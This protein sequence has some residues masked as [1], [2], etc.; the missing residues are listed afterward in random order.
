MEQLFR[1]RENGT[2][3]LT[4][5]R[6]G[7]TTFIA[8]AYIIFLNPVF[9][10]ATGMDSAGILA[11]TCLSAAVGTMLSAFFSNKPFAMA[12]GMGMNAYFTYTLCFGYGYSWQQAL[13]LTFISGGIF[14][15]LALLVGKRAVSFIPENLRHAITAGI[16]IFIMLIGM[17]DAGI[18]QMTAGFPEI[19]DLRS[20]PVI[21]ALIGL[22]VIIILTVLKVKGSLIIGM[23][24]TVVFSLLTKQITLPNSVLALPT[25][26]KDVSFHLDFAGLVGG[27]GVPAITTLIAIIISMT[28]VD[29]FDTLGF[30]IGTSSKTRGTGGSSDNLEKVMIADAGS[31]MIGALCGTSTVTVYAE[32]ASGIEAGGRTG[33]TALVTAACFLLAVFFSPIASIFNSSIT[34]PALIVVGSYLAMEIKNVRFD[35]MDDTLP[36]LFTVVMMPMAYSIT[37]GIATGFIS[38]VICKLAAGKK[39]EISMATVILCLIFIVYFIVN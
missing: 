22:L 37:V 18:I 28:I 4:E 31:T 13:A 11:A 36:A 20:L 39:K 8:M 29:M 1:L 35:T 19:G 14:L 33:L 3:V 34:A 16:G 6:A 27:E 5:V 10:S 7:L 2:T 17:L 24:I 38:Y 9:L 30:L 21:T 15:I 25:A 12:S 26:L 32:S 23:L